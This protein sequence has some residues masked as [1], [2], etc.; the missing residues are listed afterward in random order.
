MLPALGHATMSPQSPVDASVT[1][2]QVSRYGRS[3]EMVRTRS[4]ILLASAL[5]AVALFAACSS[6]SK[7]S[8]PTTVANKGFNISTPE[9]QV[10]LSLN[11]NLPPD[12]PSAFPVPS[13]A[14]AAGS[15]SLGGSEKGG[16]VAVYT[17]SGSPSDTYN[18]YK[19]NSSLTVTQ[20]KNVGIG[21]AFVGTVEFSGNYSGSANIVG[22]NSTTYLVIVLKSSGAATSAAAATT[23]TTTT[24]TS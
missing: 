23:T 12:W 21:G 4:L 6:S 19:T 16:M 8:T 18:F 2:S 20:A 13:D 1:F 11:G 10:S 15:G 9:G 5:C 17:V 22:R 7:S 24:T 3:R 14:T